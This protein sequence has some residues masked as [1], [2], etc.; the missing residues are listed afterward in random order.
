[1]VQKSPANS[2]VKIFVGDT[3]TKS[4]EHRTADLANISNARGLP[5]VVDNAVA[6]VYDVSNAVYLPIGGVGVFEEAA[7]IIPRTGSTDR[8]VGTIISYTVQPIW[9]A[10]AGD[11][12]LLI[13]FTH[14]DGQI[15]TLKYRFRTTEKK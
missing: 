8:D 6:M 15:T 7:T 2:K 11:Y 9:T 5:G 3:F 14:E 10:L 4:F 1:V 12:S 13:T